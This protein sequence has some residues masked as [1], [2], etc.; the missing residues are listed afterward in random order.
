M[1]CVPGKGI[2]H[3]TLYRGTSLGSVP[4]CI[5][6][7]E[8]MICILSIHQCRSVNRPTWK[9]LVCYFVL[10]HISVH[11]AK[12]FNT[13]ALQNVCTT[14]KSSRYNYSGEI[15]TQQCILLRS[16]VRVCVDVLD[17]RIVTCFWGYFSRGLGLKLELGLGAQLSFSG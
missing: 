15:E 6:W 8:I 17:T 16:N 7:A 5:Q 2:S 1:V 9:C 12:S 10:I 11:L 3:P 13:S 14:K 4:V